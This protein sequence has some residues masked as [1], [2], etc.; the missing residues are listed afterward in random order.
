M[1][2]VEKYDTQ[3]VSI[4]QTGGVFFAEYVDKNK[5]PM[6]DLA[7]EKCITT[8]EYNG[9]GLLSVA[10]IGELKRDSEKAGEFFQTGFELIGTPNFSFEFTCAEDNPIV[11]MLQGIQPESNGVAK[12]KDIINPKRVYC[13]MYVRYT[14]DTILRRWGAGQITE[15]KEGGQERGKMNT[16]QFTFAWQPCEETDWVPFFEY[17]GKPNATGVRG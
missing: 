4:P 17:R 16:R 12:V 5:V 8:Q 3:N 9:P 10:G 7:K 15:A 6:A 1:A 2:L 11:N 13:Y 14:N